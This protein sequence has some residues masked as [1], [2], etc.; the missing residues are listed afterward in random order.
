LKLKKD[1]EP[2]PSF[3]NLMEDESSL[4]KA[5]ALLASNIR[6]EVCGVLYSFFSFLKKYE[7]NKAHNMVSLMLDLRF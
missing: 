2:L 1:R 7:K 5:L 3:E 6:K 4:A